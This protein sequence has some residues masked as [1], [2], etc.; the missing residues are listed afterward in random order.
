[1]A[2]LEQAEWDG[3]SGKMMNA[4]R[5][6]YRVRS[7]PMKSSLL[8]VDGNDTAFNP[9]GSTVSPRSRF[10]A[11]PG[12]RQCRCSTPLASA[13]VSCQFFLEKVPT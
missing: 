9:L 6:E 7:A 2:L 3:R 4:N 13:S 8:F 11:C 12:D 10:A 5:A 1:M